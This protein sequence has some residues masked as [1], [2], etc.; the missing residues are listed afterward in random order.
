MDIY[1][2]RRSNLQKLAFEA[3]L[4]TH[5][6]LGD[7]LDKPPSLISQLIGKNPT[8][9]MGA[10]LAREIETAFSR[11]DGWLDQL[12]EGYTIISVQ[13]NGDQRVAY[14]AEEEYSLLRQFRRIDDDKKEAL[15][16]LIGDE[17]ILE[18]EE[19]EMLRKYR[20][21]N[22]SQRRAVESIMDSMAPS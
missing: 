4:K 22:E 18:P 3:G 8:R 12:H 20:R 15:K 14:L 16:V 2:I 11:P 1:E 9:N 21:L 13:D 7:L 17:D 10:K 19:R 6:A 5:A